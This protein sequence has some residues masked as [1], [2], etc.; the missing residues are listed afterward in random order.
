MKHFFQ[1]TGTGEFSLRIGLPGQAPSPFLADPLTPSRHRAP[2]CSPAAL[3]P[4]D[5]QRDKLLPWGAAF[6]GSL[7]LTGHLEGGCWITQSTGHGACLQRAAS[8][9]WKRGSIS[10]RAWPV[11]FFVLPGGIRGV[12]DTDRTLQ[13]QYFDSEGHLLRLTPSYNV[14]SPSQPPAGQT[15]RKWDGNVWLLTIHL[16]AFA[17]PWCQPAQL[18]SKCHLSNPVVT[19]LH[20]HRQMQPITS[21]NCS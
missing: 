5:L 10:S 2:D 16:F 3:Q 11:A 14:K 1:L 8:L 4:A 20:V 7:F 21:S 13:A 6:Q 19:Q 18:L 9:S 17:L 12:S 15:D